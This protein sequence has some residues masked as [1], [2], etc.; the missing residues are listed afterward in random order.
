MQR[1]FAERRK[2]F[3]AMPGRERLKANLRRSLRFAFRG[4]R[5]EHDAH[6]LLHALKDA[7]VDF[8]LMA[9]GRAVDHPDVVAGAAQVIA[10]LLKARPAQETGHGDEAHDAR[11]APRPVVV[12]FPRRPA[13]EVNVEVAQVL[14]VRA[15]APFARRHPVGQRRGFFRR[16]ILALDPA[17]ASL[18]LLLVGRIANDDGDR[19]VALDLVRVLPGLGNGRDDLRQVALV[20]LGIPERVGDEHARGRLRRP[21]GEIDDLGEDAQLRDG[22]R[23]ELHLKGDEPADGGV[24]RLLHGSFA[25]VGLDGLGNFPQHAQDVG[26]G[27]GRGISDGHGRRGQPRVLPEARTA[28]GLIDELNHRADDFG[29]RV[30]RA[31]QFAERVVIDLEEVFVEVEPGFGPALADGRPMHRVEHAGQCAEGSFERG[32]ILRVV[33]E[34]PERR[35]DERTGLGEFLGHFAKAVR[36]PDALRAGHEQ[37]EGHGLRVAVGEL[38][39]RRLGKEQHPPVL[40]QPGQGFAAQRQLLGHFVAQ[41]A[42][43]T[44]ADMGEFLGA[45]RRNRLPTEK[46]LEQ[47]QQARRCLEFAA[48]SFDVANQRDD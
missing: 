18:G 45:A 5:G 26:A 47:T 13:P 2:L 6:G 15:H 14:A 1:E 44:R 10:H 22:E 42:A 48:G 19:L 27:A 32:L 30:V 39:V 21:A 37:A 8:R 4:T 29:R 25:F 33:G 20:V 40:G 16:G 35:A 41:Q 23:P 17:A 36:E 34:Q 38:F 7:R 31:G 12:S 9:L 43:E 46:P 11:L 3:R 24:D 28:Q